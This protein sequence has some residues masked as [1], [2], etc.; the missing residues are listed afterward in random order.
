[1]AR[2]AH[3]AGIEFRD[4][5]IG[6]AGWLIE[7]HVTLYAKVEGFD[8]SFEAL[9]ARILA[10]YIETRDPQVDRARIVPGSRGKM[11]SAL[12]PSSA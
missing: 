6:D 9:V 11:V 4:L 3:G 8:A 1:M 10:E 12:G 5:V 2:E 7:Q